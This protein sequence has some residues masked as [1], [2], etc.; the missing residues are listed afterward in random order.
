LAL[1]DSVQKRALRIVGSR[2]L[3]SDFDS[4][5]HRRNVADLVVFYKY[6][7]RQCSDEVLCSMPQAYIHPVTL[8]SQLLQTAR[9]S[10]FNAV[11]LTE[12]RRIFYPN[13]L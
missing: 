2:S 7:H 8:D 10:K 6:R 3:T 12:C 13:C 9:P 4:L 11:I 5:Q 1:L